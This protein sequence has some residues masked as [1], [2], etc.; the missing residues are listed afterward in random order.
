MINP[1][2]FYGLL[3]HAINRDIGRGRKQKFS[4]AFLAPRSATP[5]PFLQLADSAVQLP[6]GWVAVARM[7]FFEVIANALQVRGGGGRPTDTHV[8][9]RSTPRTGPTTG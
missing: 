3:S 6:H 8:Y 9:E 7:V 2:D 4:G 5:R 1:H